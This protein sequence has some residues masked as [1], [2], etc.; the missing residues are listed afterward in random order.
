MNK[1]VAKYIPATSISEGAASVPAAMD[2]AG[3]PFTAIDNANWAEDYPYK[4]KVDFRIAHTGTQIVLHYRVE[5][6]TVRATAADNGNVWEDSCCEFFVCPE[7]GGV[8]YNIECNCAGQMLIGSGPERNGRT[9]ATQGV[10]DTVSRWSSIGREPFDEK[11]APT[12]WELALVV[13]V[14]A[15]YDS[16]F[17]NLAGK[18]VR[19]NFYKCGD[20]LTTP[21]F[22]SW[23]PISV[24]KPNFHLPE[25]FGEVEFE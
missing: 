18:T 12:V 10:L 23:N 11:Q 6:A 14:S 24:A 5:E 19:A 15:L 1:T 13:P 25:F 17:E 22:L 16:K 20:K 9:R 21:H 3:V 2:A 7:A 4:P 8:Y